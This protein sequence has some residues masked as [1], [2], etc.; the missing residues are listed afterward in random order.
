VIVPRTVPA[1]VESGVS[2]PNL[3]LSQHLFRD[4]D[5][6][7]LAALDLKC[8]QNAATV[9]T[10][11]ADCFRFGKYGEKK[12][13]VRGLKASHPFRSGSDRIVATK[14]QPSQVF[15]PTPFLHLFRV[16]AGHRPCYIL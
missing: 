15:F 12:A 4:S 6:R 2:G 13:G 11:I 14:G 7:L 16:A 9:R 10:E 8:G 1:S 5:S 3:L